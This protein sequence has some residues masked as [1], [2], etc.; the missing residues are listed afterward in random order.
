MVSEVEGKHTLMTRIINWYINKL[1]IAA[2]NDAEVSV[3][4]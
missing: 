3:A 2:Q 1:H 4:F